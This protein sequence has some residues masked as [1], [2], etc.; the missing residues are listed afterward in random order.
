MEV[1]VPS[2]SA[3]VPLLPFTSVVSQPRVTWATPMPPNV[4]QVPGVHEGT[5]L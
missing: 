2:E 3:Q 5:H 1:D 4:W